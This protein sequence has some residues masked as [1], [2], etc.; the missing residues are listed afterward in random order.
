VPWN[1]VCES[2]GKLEG[3]KADWNIA[4]QSFRL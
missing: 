1:F 2:R 4:A 3:C